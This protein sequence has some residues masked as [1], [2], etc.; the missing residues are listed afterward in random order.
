MLCKQMP[1]HVFGAPQCWPFWTKG[2]FCQLAQFGP[3]WKF[4]NNYLF[5][6]KIERGLSFE[7][8][9]KI[10]YLE[11]HNVG[12]FKHMGVSADWSKRDQFW[13]FVKNK[14]SKRV[15]ILW[16]SEI[17]VANLRPPWN[18]CSFGQ[19]NIRTST[20]Y[21]HWGLYWTE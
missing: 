15:Y 13:I 12:H 18:C 20:W 16:K 3:I 10:M 11:P 4:L 5:K 9:C 2:Y 21:P 7:K 17:S 8:I 14:N 1:T 19:L 6:V